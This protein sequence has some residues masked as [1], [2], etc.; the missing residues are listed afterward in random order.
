M[1]RAIVVGSGAGGAAAALDLQGAFDVTVIEA[2]REFRPFSL[3]MPVLDRLKKLGHHLDTRWI[4]RLFPAMR[5]AKTGDMVLVFGRGLGGTTTIATGNAL[6]L[7]TNLKAMGIDLDPEFEDISRRV[8]ISTAHEAGWRPMTRR[9]YE[10]CGEMGLAPEPLPKFGDYARCRHCGRCVLG[11]P[12]GVKWDARF[13]LRAAEEKGARVVTGT[14]VERL[15]ID[16]RGAKGVAVRRGVKRRFVP[17]DLIV[18]AAGGL[19]TPVILDQSGIRGEPRLF[20]DP[21][22]TVA[23]E[24]P[25][26]RGAAEVAMPF[27]VDKG[28]YIISP[29]FDFL[30]FV[31]DRRWRPPS[32]NVLS[33]MIKLADEPAGEARARGIRKTLSAVDRK[34]L[35]EAVEVTTEIMGR[36]GVPRGKIFLGTINAGHPGG[37]FPLGPGE[38]DTF[39]HAPLPPNVYIADASLFPDSLGKPPIMTIMAM[40]KRVARIARERLG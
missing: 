7:D 3:G 4:S 16:D 21:V 6:R 8:P 10:I 14:K 32:R 17:A 15:V 39:H 31:F 1:K 22:L 37:M 20:V 5:T 34:H 13:F 18:L 19:G 25:D 36:V 24:W 27:V 33:I 2:G 26:A 11:C 12:Y 35:A 23:A 29:Y 40:A 38:K 30:S 28:K 9:L